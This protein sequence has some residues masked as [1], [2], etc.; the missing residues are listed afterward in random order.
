MHAWTV[1]YRVMKYGIYQII[2][3]YHTQYLAT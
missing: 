3:G 2:K 1:P